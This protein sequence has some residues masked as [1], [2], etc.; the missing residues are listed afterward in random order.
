MGRHTEEEFLAVLL[1]C[2]PHIRIRRYTRSEHNAYYHDVEKRDAYYRAVGKHW[3]EHLKGTIKTS[4]YAW[5]IFWL[6]Y[7]EYVENNHGP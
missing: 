4:P 7:C 1:S 2:G 5:L 6:E 3:V